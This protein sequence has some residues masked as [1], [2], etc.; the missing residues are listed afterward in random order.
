MYYLLLVKGV[1]SS[2]RNKIRVVVKA[3][4]APV[5]LIIIAK[6]ISPL[7]SFRERSILIECGDDSNNRKIKFLRHA[8]LVDFKKQPTST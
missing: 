7:L 4:K 2:V 3:L 6:L 1:S 5:T 8:S